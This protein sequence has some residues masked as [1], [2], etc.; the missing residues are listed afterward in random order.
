M[1][2]RL[3]LLCALCCVALPLL[4]QDAAAPLAPD[5]FI[6]LV[7][8][9]MG[10][11]NTVPAANYHGPNADMLGRVMARF[12]KTGVSKDYC[13]YVMDVP[14]WNAFASAGMA[15]PDVVCVWTGLLKDMTCD[16]ELAGVVAHEMGHNRQQHGKKQ[17]ENLSLA[18]LILAGVLP[19][20][21]ASDSSALFLGMM[22]LG[23]SRDNEAEADRIGLLTATEAGYNPEKLVAMWKRVAAKSGNAGP[24]LL[25]DHPPTTSRITALQKLMKTHM[26]KNADGTYLVTN[27]D[28]TQPVSIGT[29]L[30]RGALLGLLGGGIGAGYDVVENGNTDSSSVAVHA[31]EWAAA[32]FAIGAVLNIDFPPSLRQHRSD[33]AYGATVIRT[34]NGD[35]A[36]VVFGRVAF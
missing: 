30:E 9:Q 20:N 10:N 24:A 35:A 27:H 12:A 34:V 13:W 33:A 19:S 28:F 22:R 25:L 7:G 26:R 4:A 29:R 36:P 14:Q 6:A 1:L 21:A 18:G 2:R 5:A 8:K 3:L 32:G 17:M 31:G 15:R 23:F 16:D 11:P